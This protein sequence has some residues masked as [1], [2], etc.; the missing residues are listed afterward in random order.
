[1]AELEEGCKAIANGGKATNSVFAHPL[2]FNVIPH[3]DKFLEDKY[4][5]EERKVRERRGGSG[6]GWRED[7]KEAVQLAEN[8]CAGVGEWGG[9]PIRGGGERRST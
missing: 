8:Y 1:M 9:Q 7:R 4:T 6:E 2:P 5:K 3:I